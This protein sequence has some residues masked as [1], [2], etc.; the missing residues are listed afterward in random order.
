M[1]TH[2]I[3]LGK[4]ICAGGSVP[5]EGTARAKAPRQEAPWHAGGTAG[6]P[7]GWRSEAEKWEVMLGG[8]GGRADTQTRLVLCVNWAEFEQVSHMV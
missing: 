8:K 1:K 5:G 3:R 4:Q 7:C 6:R 2:R